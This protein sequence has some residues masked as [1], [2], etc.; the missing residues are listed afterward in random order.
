[1]SADHVAEV[2]DLAEARLARAPDVERLPYTLGIRQGAICLIL[3]TPI[4]DNDVEL[5][6]SADKALELAEDLR[7]TALAAKWGSRG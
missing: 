3:G 4:D 5:W 7:R 2:I 1:M 6:M